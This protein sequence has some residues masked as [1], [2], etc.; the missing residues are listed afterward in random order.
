MFNIFQRSLIHW[1]RHGT[2]SLFFAIIEFIRRRVYILF[3]V[4]LSHTPKRNGLVLFNET[5]G[6]TDNTAH[7]ANYLRSN[8]DSVE[9][10]W[11]TREKKV[12][13]DLVNKNGIRVV[14]ENSLRHFATLIRAEILFTTH[15]PKGLNV[16]AQYADQPKI[17]HL[18]HGFPIR[19][20]GQL[21]RPRI[22]SKTSLMK[23][24]K[25]FDYRICTSTFAQEIYTRHNSIN[26]ERILVTGLPRNDSL[27]CPPIEVEERWNK[28]F[29]GKPPKRTVLY[30]PTQ[31]IKHDERELDF[32]WLLDDCLGAER[33]H[34]YLAA[35]DVTLLIRLHPND[36]KKAFVTKQDENRSV[37]SSLDVLRTSDQ[38]CLVNTNQNYFAEANEILP[39]IDVLMTDY[40]SIYHDFLLLDRPVFFAPYDYQKFKSEGFTYNYK[41]NLPG[42]EIY[43][44]DDL[45]TQIDSVLNGTD[46]FE[47]SRHA[48][49][50]KI[51]TYQDNDSCK[52]VMEEVN[53]IRLC[54]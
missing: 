46:N 20:I 51:H 15:S 37:K 3:G 49:R 43:N 52:R 2:R 16:A 4:L 48:L 53:R 25:K 44:V 34:E 30:A 41:A 54:S 13:N 27:L 11:V 14:K 29:D 26:K 24:R 1:N 31:R 19:A 45:I 5:Y 36:Y 21:K 17:I 50:N 8:Q 9:P 22:Y 47:S 23:S 42:P 39:M 12:F 6:Y 38:V 33:L 40:S 28:Y 7:L 32:D 35:R 10:V 18:H